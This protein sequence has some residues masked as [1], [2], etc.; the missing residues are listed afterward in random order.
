MVGPD[1][2]T[3]AGSLTLA[4]ELQLHRIAAVVLVRLLL[5]ALLGTAEPDFLAEAGRWAGYAVVG[6]AIVFAYA[7]LLRRSSTGARPASAASARPAHRRSPAESPR[8][9]AGTQVDLHQAPA[10]HAAGVFIR[11]RHTHDH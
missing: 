2:S 8:N 10:R 11:W 6:G 1:L 4:I 3:T 5:G 7:L 9:A